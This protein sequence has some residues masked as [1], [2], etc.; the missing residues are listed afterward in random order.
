[1]FQ[2]EAPHGFDYRPALS[3]TATPHQRLATMAGAMDWVLSLQQREAAKATSEDAK[4][5]AHKRYDD[6][7][8]NLSKAFALAAASD[9]AQEIRDEV[10][11]FQAIRVALGKDTARSGMSMGAPQGLC[12]KQR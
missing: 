8:A 11:F 2:P 9:E 6:A 3:P 5:K 10:G 1:M 4:K 12:A 7:V